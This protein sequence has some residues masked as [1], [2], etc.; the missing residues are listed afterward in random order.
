MK[1]FLAIA[2][3]AVMTFGVASF[4][5]CGGNGDVTKMN[6]KSVDV[7]TEEKKAEFMEE[8]TTN[9]KPDT[10]FGDTSATDFS[11]GFAYAMNYGFDVSASVGDMS[12]S[13]KVDGNVDNDIKISAG[14]VLV[15]GTSAIKSN[16]QLP[17]GLEI[18]AEAKAI[19]DFISNM[20]LTAKQYLDGEYMYAELPQSYID[21]LP[22]EVAGMFPENGK[23]KISLGDIAGNLSI[24]DY[25]AE[26]EV[27]QTAELVAGVMGML[28]N[29]DVKIE[30][31]TDSG[32]A[33]KLTADKDAI[34]NIIGDMTGETSI[35]TMVNTFA[36]FN[37]CEL[38]AYLAVDKDGMFKEVAI[39]LNL[40]VKVN[41]PA[42][43]L[44]DDVPAISADAKANIDMSVKT[45]NGTVTLPT[46]LTDYTDLTALMG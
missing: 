1:K 30:T 41:I 36:T 35:S 20:D 4:A 13:A 43:T 2:A 33:I 16:V 46:D 19:I 42:N 7:S 28:I 22:S 27:N 18:D 40:D 21:A 23:V 32:Y 17:E 25:D 37:A 11:Y 8:V 3:S 45:F 12:F 34:L 6:Y 31:S 5:A 9:I 15:A 44:G 24:A 14:D 26:T 38:S 10:M 39:I 29:Y